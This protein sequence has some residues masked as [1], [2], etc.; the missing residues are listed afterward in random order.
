[1]CVDV[2]L[3]EEGTV[4]GEGGGALRSGDHCLACKLD[5]RIPGHN[6]SGLVHSGPQV[7]ASYV[8]IHQTEEHAE[9]I[10][11]TGSP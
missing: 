5:S 10:I 9:K 4:T 1:M 6:P 8:N 7:Q 11:C 3:G 2:T